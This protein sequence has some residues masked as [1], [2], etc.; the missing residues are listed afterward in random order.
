M[1]FYFSHKCDRLAA[2]TGGIRHQVKGMREMHNLSFC[3]WLPVL[4]EIQAFD[5]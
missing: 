4:V 1:C 5:R 2:M 3:W